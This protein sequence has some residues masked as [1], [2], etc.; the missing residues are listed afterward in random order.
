MPRTSVTSPPD[1]GVPGG[2]PPPAGPAGEQSQA[3][4]VPEEDGDSG[5]TPTPD[6]E[7]DTETSTENDDSPSNSQSNVVDI[8]NFAKQNKDVVF[9]IPNKDAPNGYTEISVDKAASILGQTG[10]VNEKATKLKQE[11]AAFEEQ[12]KSRQ[13]HIDGLTL[14][15]ELEL[16][17]ALQTAAEEL[18]TL[19][20]YQA[21]WQEYHDR[22]ADNPEEQAK[23][24]AA[25]KKN[26]ALIKEATAFIKDKRPKVNHYFEQ[27]GKQ[28]SH[29]LEEARKGFKD[30]SLKN[31]HNYTE[32]RNVLEKNWGN[33]KVQMIPGVNNIDLVS[34]DEFILGLLRDGFRYRNAPKAGNAGKSVVASKDTKKTVTK[35]DNPQNDLTS[36]ARQGD[37]QA[38]LD[39]LTAHLNQRRGR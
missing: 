14:A 33:S 16:V 31:T 34:S 7:N 23:A 8:V 17:P 1:G 4:T 38:S 20:E 37:R 35:I 26:D 22:N 15:L 6:S 24:V 11:R 10:A 36:R 30:E 19:Q 29:A 25:L 32:L 39:L 2:V 12:M 3:P 21:Q 13:S 27:R 18:V 28:V 9:R 5:N